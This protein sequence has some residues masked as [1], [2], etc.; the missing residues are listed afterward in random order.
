MDEKVVLP[1]IQQVPHSPVCDLGDC[2]LVFGPTD[3]CARLVS[4]DSTHVAS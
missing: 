4:N 1:L 3:Q 2:R